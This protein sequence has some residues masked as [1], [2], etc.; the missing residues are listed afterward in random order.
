VRKL[1]ESGAQ[2]LF[3]TNYIKLKCKNQGIYQYVV[4]YDPPIDAQY[5]RIKLL[6][7]LSNITG[8]VRLFDGYTLFLP[9]LLDKVFM[10]NYYYY[11]LIIYF[12]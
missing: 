4:H 8:P 5:N 2:T 12:F 10:R 9:I 3:S 1:G 7:Q 11:I 6:Y